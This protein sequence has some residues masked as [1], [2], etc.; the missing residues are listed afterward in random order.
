[1]D[2][3]PNFWLFVDFSK[4]NLIILTKKQHNGYYQ[5]WIF[6]QQADPERRVY[7]VTMGRPIRPLWLCDNIMP[8]SG[9]AVWMLKAPNSLDFITTGACSRFKKKNDSK[10]I[11]KVLNQYLGFLGHSMLV[12][13]IKQGRLLNRLPP[14]P[15]PV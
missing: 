5:P 1:M 8:P 2:K 4:I 10:I 3:F 15:M 14:V 7:C 6:L 9:T 11:N 13:F 12:W